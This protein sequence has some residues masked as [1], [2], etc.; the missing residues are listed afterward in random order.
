MGVKIQ[1]QSNDERHSTDNRQAGNK[2]IHYLSK[3]MYSGFVSQYQIEIYKYV[4]H[5]KNE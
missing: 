3:F 4:Q 5:K 2:I 1:E